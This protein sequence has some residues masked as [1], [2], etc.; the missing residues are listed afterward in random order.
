MFIVNLASEGL[1]Q[2]GVVNETVLLAE[3]RETLRLFDS[4]DV[5][6]VALPCN[7]VYAYFDQ[8]QQ[9]T[10]AQVV[11]LPEE[12]ALAATEL[13]A[14]DIGI[15]CSQGLRTARAYDPYFLARGI[16][17]Y[18]PEEAIQELI[19]RWILE[20]MGGDHTEKT[21]ARLLDVVNKLSCQHD[22]VVLACSELCVL[23]DASS[24]PP[25][26]INSCR[27]LAEATLRSSS[28]GIV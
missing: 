26:V 18:Y 21:V 14:K 25:S 1:S 17:P 27:V 6:V 22:A 16:E 23:V 12:I 10:Q 9:Y 7:S 2:T 24:L 8:F 15:L 19:D 20:V 11:N 3:I 4:L 5:R 13:Q 28:G